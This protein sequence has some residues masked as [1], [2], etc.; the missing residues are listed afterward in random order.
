VN[1][2]LLY[3]PFVVSRYLKDGPDDMVVVLAFDDYNN[4][5]SAKS[6][7]QS[8]RKQKVVNVLPFTEDDDIPTGPCPLAWDGA[9]CN[10]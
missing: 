6:M 3:T 1:F 8:R 5:P 9:M 7:T 10:R 2:A 4:V